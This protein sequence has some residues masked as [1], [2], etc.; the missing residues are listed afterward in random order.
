[1][2]TP[3]CGVLVTPGVTATL[4][5]MPLGSELAAPVEASMGRRQYQR[6]DGLDDHRIKCTP[7]ASLRFPTRT[8][9]LQQTVVD[10]IDYHMLLKR[11]HISFFS[12][13]LFSA[14]KPRQR[15][16]TAHVAMAAAGSMHYKLS[17]AATLQLTRGDLTRFDGDAIVNA[18]DRSRRMLHTLIPP[19]LPP[20]CHPMLRGSHLHWRPLW[21]PLASPLTA[22][23][24]RC[25][26]RAHAWRRRR[27]WSHPQSSRTRLVRRMPGG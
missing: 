23:I 27:G 14:L 21:M 24:H 8:M 15:V 26:E 6:G 20:G 4:G 9:L 17:K 13:S 18:G 22:V 1:V 25:S 11:S 16:G 12:R 7:P 10:P 5:S 2:S 19:P 3:D